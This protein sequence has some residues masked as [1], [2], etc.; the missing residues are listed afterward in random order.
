MLATTALMRFLHKNGALALRWVAMCCQELLP[1]H[2]VSVPHSAIT[3]LDFSVN[4]LPA[5]GGNESDVP[6]DVPGCG[7]AGSEKHH[8]APRAVFGP[9]CEGWPVSYLCPK[10]HAEWHQRMRC[11]LLVPPREPGSKE[12]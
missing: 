5:C 1:T 8:W 4:Q 11:L 10:H 3:S 6:C 12:Q 9:E 7:A 2:G